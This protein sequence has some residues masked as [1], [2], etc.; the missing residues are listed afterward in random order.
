MQRASRPDFLVYTPLVGDQ[1]STLEDINILQVSPSTVK[2]DLQ[3]E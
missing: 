3:A 2:V 1:S